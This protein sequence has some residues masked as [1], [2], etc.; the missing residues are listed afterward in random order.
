MTVK[1]GYRHIVIAEDSI[2]LARTLTIRPNLTRDAIS[3]SVTR[4][5][6]IKGRLGGLAASQE[7]NCHLSLRRKDRL[8]RHPPCSIRGIVVEDG[9]RTGFR[10]G[11]R[12]IVLNRSWKEQIAP[13]A[14]ENS[15]LGVVFSSSLSEWYGLGISHPAKPD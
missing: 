11:T 7:I 5:K 3:C 6:P 13:R 4:P 15:V 1:V 8:G 10:T 2:L 9:H 14:M 12:I